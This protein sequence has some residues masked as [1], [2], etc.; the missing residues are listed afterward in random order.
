GGRRK[1]VKEGEGVIVTLGWGGGVDGLPATLVQSREDV[2]T[3]RSQF[4]PFSGVACKLGIELNTY[5]LNE[6]DAWQP[7]LIDVHGKI[8]SQT[9]GLVLINP[10][11]PTGSVCSR[12]MLEQ[13]ADLARRNNLVIFADEIY[14]KLILDGG[15]PERGQTKRGETKR[16]Q[17]ENDKHVSM[18]AVAPDVP[19]VTFGGLSKNYLAPGWRKI[20]RAH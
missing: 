18:A 9:R 6:D 8:N 19:V 15:Q 7:D 10:N 2:L 14:D 1:G 4:P 12:E 13:I 11:N 17:T 16:L 20:G 5:S 3:A